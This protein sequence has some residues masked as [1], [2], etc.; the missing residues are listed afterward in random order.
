MAERFCPNFSNENVLSDFN[1]I[2]SKFNG[3]PL[4]VKDI[5]HEGKELYT[6]DLTDEETKALN[7]S[8]QLWHENEGDMNKINEIIDKV[9]IKPQEEVD[10]YSYLKSLEPYYKDTYGIDIPIV[11]EEKY[12]STK[13]VTIS[14]DFI[15]ELNSILQES[16]Y[17]SKT[18]TFNPS[19]KISTGTKSNKKYNTD[20]ESTLTNFVHKLGGN[21]STYQVFAD[22]TGYDPIAIA[23]VFNKIIL[24]NENKLTDSVLAEE[25]G[26]LAIASIPKDNGLYNRLISLMDPIYKSILGD[27]FDVYDKQYKGDITKLKEEA[28]GQLL[29]E[30]VIKG[31]KNRTDPTLFTALQ[32]I[33]EWFKNLFRRVTTADLNIEVGDILTKVAN[34]ILSE[35]IENFNISKIDTI[36]ENKPFFALGSSGTKR[37]LDS[38]E[39]NLKELMVKLNKRVRDL[40]RA[41]KTEL[42]ESDKEILKSIEKDYDTGSYI[43][44]VT[45]VIEQLRDVIVGSEDAI[46]K[47]FNEI[48]DDINSGKNINFREVSSILRRAKS[49]VNSFTDIISDII[50][51]L[52]LYEKSGNTEYVELKDIAIKVKE[53]LNLIDKRYYELGVPLFAGFLQEFIPVE[54]RSKIDLVKTLKFLDKDI[55]FWERWL[56]AMNDSS[57]AVLQLISEAVRHYKAYAAGEARKER[58]SLVSELMKLEDAGHK[59]TEWMMQ[60]KNGKFTGYYIA[61]YDYGKRKEEMTKFS[62]ELNKKFGLPNNLAERN[63][64]LSIDPDLDYS[65]KKEWGMWHEENSQPHPDF[66][67][68]IE[69]SKK[70]MTKEEFNSWYYDNITYANEIKPLYYEQTEIINGRK[71]KTLHPDYGVT[72]PS[73]KYRNTDF[74]KL[75]DS[76]KEFYNKVIDIKRKYEKYLPE[77]YRNLYR[78]V[79]IRG[80]FVEKVKATG[81]I[82]TV[83]E[84]IKESLQV[85]KDNEE[86]MGAFDED[87]Y[88]VNFLP[89]FFTAKLEDP[90]LLSPDVVGTMSAF[91]AM[92]SDYN[93][94][95]KILDVIELGKDIIEKREVSKVDAKGRPIT[96][97]VKVLGIEFSREIF[98]KDKSFSMERLED[99]FNMI[100]YGHMREIKE[101]SVFGKSMDREKLIDN[102]NK[103]TALNNLALNTYAGISNI[104]LGGTMHRIE[105]V[106]GEYISNKNSLVADKIYASELLGLLSQIGSRYHTNKMER[107]VDYFNV[108][109]DFKEKVREID[110]NKKNVFSRLFNS[111]ALFFTNSAGEHWI[112]TRMALALADTIKLKDKNGKEINL[113]DAYEVKGNSLKLKD[114]ITKLDGS[115]WTRADEVNFEGRVLAINQRINGIY[116][117]IDRSAIQKY[118]LGRMALLFR[119]FIKPGINRRWDKLQYNYQLKGETEGYYRTFLRFLFKDLKKYQFSLVKSWDSLNTMQ[120]SNIKRTLMDI[121][122]LIGA[123]VLLSFMTN[124]DGD[125]D[126]WMYNMMSYQLH[127]LRTDLAFYWNPNEALRI[128]QSPAAGVSTIQNWLNFINFANVSRW[129]QEL[130]SGK[131][132]GITRFEKGLIMSVPPLKTVYDI[133]SPEEKLTFFHMNR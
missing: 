63:A 64:I 115:S 53:S 9:T 57:D 10:L 38:T 98:K 8:Y 33:W 129:G 25:V 81:W 18:Q 92:A 41:G 42:A 74:D 40:Y 127:R 109:D 44:G 51:E 30:A 110:A 45:K 4:E 85:M 133:T 118:A 91:V 16:D 70:S 93:Q 19:L 69:Q 1:K 75:T 49:N 89:I 68:F 62:E 54:M 124:S 73:E 36:Y 87:G 60:K 77:K 22:K 29:G 130:Q 31:Y 125:D 132:K 108:L 66:K 113:W 14:K 47:K 32:N 61:Q 105:A 71:I 46:F 128:M 12:I 120:R 27:K 58:D 103:Y 107:W 34:D 84:E 43:L 116:N 82:K 88:A 7:I 37:F 39:K 20:L 26:H 95:N 90:S 13:E 15:D 79:Q 23:D 48:E 101:I 96:K 5:T 111:S 119:K 114:G 24:I 3:K 102:F 121:S 55:S 35:R 21:I 28:A 6:K 117:Q 72:I 99:Y 78:A 131:Y 106:T 67:N 94:M 80:D 11:N 52:G 104:V 17:I 50:T 112:Q 100:V 126:D 86:F 76:Q 122:Y 59:D 123:T 83:K 2:I 65:Y 56:D 97:K